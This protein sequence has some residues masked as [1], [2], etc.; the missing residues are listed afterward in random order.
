[1]EKIKWIPLLLVVCLL[2][3]CN[4][5]QSV[6]S[7]Y[8]THVKDMVQAD[9]FD[10]LPESTDNIVVY[11]STDEIAGEYIEL[12]SVEMQEIN[13]HKKNK[14]M[15]SRLIEEAIDL[16][17]NGIL[18]LSSTKT[19][20]DGTTKEEMKAIAIYDLDRAPVINPLAK[21]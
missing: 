1:M 21:M 18:V 8:F 17:S 13:N 6:N 14:E 3:G 12:A 20:K 19:E 9:V 5:S 15:M 4:T 10:V 2:T 16:G 7:E 11:N